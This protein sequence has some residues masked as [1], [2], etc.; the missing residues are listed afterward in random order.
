MII[1]IQ[2]PFGTLDQ[3]LLDYVKV[4]IMEF[5]KMS[6]RVTRADVVF[7]LDRN[8]P[9]ENK[10]CEVKIQLGDEVFFAQRRTG[11]FEQSAIRVLEA[12][13]QE[14]HQYFSKGDELPDIVLSTVKP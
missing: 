1:E 10:K 6:S 13:R 2:K 9:V 8:E 3:E 14:L 7:H 11:S 12:L 5:S 4:K